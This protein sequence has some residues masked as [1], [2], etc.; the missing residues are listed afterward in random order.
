MRTIGKTRPINSPTLNANST[1]FAA[2]ISRW[3][4]LPEATFCV[5]PDAT[6]ATQLK[7][8]FVG[9]QKLPPIIPINRLLTAASVLPPPAPL[10]ATIPLLEEIHE[11]NEQQLLW[12][13]YELLQPHCYPNNNAARL[14]LAQKLTRLFLEIDQHLPDS[15]QHN[16]F[17]RL[18]GGEH[19]C[20][21]EGAV[22]AAVWDLLN[23]HKIRIGQQPIMQALATTLPP[24]LAITNDYT[25]PAQL[26]FYQQCHAE[27]VHL[28]NTAQQ[29]QLIQSFTLTGTAT[30]VS[31][32]CAYEG[33]AATL[34]DTATLALNALRH[35]LHDSAET[36]KIGI[37]VYDRLLARRLR[38]AAETADIFIT[39]QSGWRAE[40]LSS[41]A[42][43][44]MYATITLDKFD[45]RTLSNIL[46]PPFYHSFSEFALAAQQWRQY[47]NQ[48][49]NIPDSIT[50]LLKMLPPTHTALITL[51]NDILTA[52]QQQ[53]QQK[54]TVT[55]WLHWLYTHAAQMLAAWQEDTIAI[56]VQQRLHQCAQHNTTAMNAD[57]FLLWLQGVLANETISDHSIKSRV[58]FTQPGT[59][60]Q[61]S[62]LLLLG[63]A[64][65]ATTEE[66]GWLGENERQLLQLPVRETRVQQQR[67][68]FCHLLA[69]HHKIAAVWCTSDTSGKPVM[70]N[71][72]WY[73]FATACRQQEKLTTLTCPADTR[74]ADNIPPPPEKIQAIAPSL[75]ATL[76]LSAADTLMTCPYLFYVNT[77]LKLRD[78]ELPQ[79]DELSPALIGT[80]LHSLL[81]Q[82]SQASSNMQEI[83]DLQLCWQDIVMDKLRGNRP[84]LALLRTYWLVHSNW[85]LAWEYNRRADGWQTEETEYTVALSL[86]LPDNRGVEINGRL[87]RLDRLAP[88]RLDRN[89]ATNMGAVIDYKSGT[90]AS[91]KEL[92]KAELPQLALYTFFVQQTVKETV[93]THEPT[94][95]MMLCRP[96]HK[97]ASVVSSEAAPRRVAARLRQVL[98]Q[99]AR[100]VPLP[101][102]GTL[103]NAC[104]NC[105]AAG[106]CRRPA[107]V[108]SAT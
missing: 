27:M 72:F 13:I 83:A 25:T 107:A 93:P 50:G 82:F 16:P 99:I 46:Q 101:A 70:P 81:S 30:E 66:H 60:R 31:D 76:P 58:E 104:I 42:A 52:R 38:A 71:P 92:T 18:Q 36:D 19:S 23:E 41:G 49:L 103:G 14:Q 100:G 22:A 40:S 91:K 34:T 2:I 90:L 3:Q 80:L 94:Y 12:H 77:L 8:A 69:A 53:P 6:I 73:L 45:M 97:D 88:N 51:T 89:S 47:L 37:V 20:S 108:Y 67:Q 85:F 35:F 63:Y 64:G 10:I 32:Y 54:A 28:E 65:P 75:P 86:S 44:L 7:K 24:F 95:E 57:E 87:D 68:Q 102:N 11:D 56:A 1:D 96:L 84:G 55:Q 39:D 74:I 62:A 48:T 59:Q 43:L 21:H 29:Q 15:H 98:K 5:V 78:Q 33:N 79:T 106:I 17:T 61:F 9:Q 4:Q 105:T 26:A